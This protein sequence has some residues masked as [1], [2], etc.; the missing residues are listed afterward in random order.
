MLCTPLLLWS[1][2]DDPPTLFEVVS[3]QVKPGMEDQFEAAVKMHNEKFH[4]EG[5][6]QAQLFYNINGPYA[7]YQWVMG[8]TNYAALDSRPAD[9][10]HDQDWAKVMDMVESA[11]PPR[12]WNT[13]IENSQLTE[14]Q[15]RDKSMVWMYDL[16][17]GKSAQWGELI[18]KVKAVYEEKRAD[19]DMFVGW[20][21]L[22]N[23]DGE[24]AVLIF[25]M[26]NWAELDEQRNFGKEYEEVHG[27]GSWHAF[28]N[29]VSEC[30]KQ[31]VDWMRE[32]ID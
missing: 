24:D 3:L 20:N 27:A 18:G 10:A 25:S 31:R 2:T 29:H 14:N 26:E 8:P 23:A 7:G 5:A 21:A 22:S 32:R 9:D 19:E 17:P 15:D 16:R 11:T 13:D 28:L 4:G 1:Q 12:Y 6:H 30:V